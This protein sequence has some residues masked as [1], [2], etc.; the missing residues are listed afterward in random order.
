MKKDEMRAI[1]GNE[2][3]MRR[4]LGRTRKGSQPAPPHLKNPR[5]DRPLEAIT[6]HDQL[7]PVAAVFNARANQWR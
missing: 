1:R 7:T 2:E 3:M 6:K 4:R 5:E